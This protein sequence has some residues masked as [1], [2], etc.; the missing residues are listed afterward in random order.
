MVMPFIMLAVLVRGIG[1]Q[2]VRLVNLLTHGGPGRTTE[3]VSITLK[4]EGIRGSGATG[5]RPRRDHSV[6]RG[7]GLA[8][9]YVKALKTR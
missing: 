4:S 3:V 8:P 7:F 9:I 2:D 1:I 6:R 5:I